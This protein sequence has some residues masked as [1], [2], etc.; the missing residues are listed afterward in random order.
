M[1]QDK[2]AEMLKAGDKKGAVELITDF[3]YAHAVDFNQRW[4]ALGDRL[5]SKYALGYTDVKATPYPEEWNEIVG[6]GVPKRGTEQK[7]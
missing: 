2:A 6:F 3:A 4:L 1:I 7:K 5:L